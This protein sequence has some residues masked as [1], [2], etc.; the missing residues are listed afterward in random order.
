MGKVIKYIFASLFLFFALIYLLMSA[1]VMPDT[2]VVA[3]DS[4]P[5]EVVASLRE[6]GII[7]D[8]EKIQYYYSEDLFSFENYGN[9]FT[10]T[11]VVSYETNEETGKRVIYSLP[12]A[13]V[14]DINFVKGESEFDD[15]IIE[16]FADNKHKFSLLVSREE[17]GDDKFYSSLVSRWKSVANN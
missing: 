2:K 4:L 14:T 6:E 13:Q 16:I 15:S 3:G 9:L 17:D 10:E 5:S 7:Q 1:G 11:R 12:L 8:G